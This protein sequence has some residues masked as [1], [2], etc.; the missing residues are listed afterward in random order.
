[1]KQEI[2]EAMIKL[3]EACLSSKWTYKYQDFTGFSLRVLTGDLKNHN[4]VITLH[5]EKSLSYYFIN[6]NDNS[7]SGYEIQS[8]NRVDYPQPNDFKNK[9]VLKNENKTIK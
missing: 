7:S 2:K 6:Y 5:E 1:M 9:E 4:L 3:F 8:L